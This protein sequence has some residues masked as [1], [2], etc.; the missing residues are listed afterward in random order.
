MDLDVAKAYH[1][2]R[3]PRLDPDEPWR[4]RCP[5]CESTQVTRHRGASRPHN[6]VY[7]CST[8]GLEQVRRDQMNNYRCL[9]CRE[10]FIRVSDVKT[11][12][13]AMP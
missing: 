10:R 13:M 3:E 2:R 7:A 1:P 12:G 5:E 9:H 11:G 6:H 4:Y 8:K